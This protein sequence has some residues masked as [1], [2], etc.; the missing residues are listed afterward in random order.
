MLKLGTTTGHCI[1][2]VRETLHIIDKHGGM[3]GF[4]LIMDNAPICAF[5]KIEAIIRDYNC[6]YLSPLSNMHQ[7]SIQ[8]GKFW[9]LIKGKVRRHKLDDTETLEE[10]VSVILLLQSQLS[11]SKTSFNRQRINSTT[12]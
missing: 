7:N 10:K 8:L 1:K 11:T 5:K 12:A 9:A 2:L 6:V 3:R 4:Y